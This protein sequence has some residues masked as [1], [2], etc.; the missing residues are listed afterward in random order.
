M[1][2]GFGSLVGCCS[3]PPVVTA[4]VVPV[5]AATASADPDA[6]WIA[7]LHEANA[8]WRAKRYSE[9]LVKVDEA[10]IIRPVDAQ[11]AI[12]GTAAACVLGDQER[13]LFYYRQIPPV[14]RGSVGNYCGKQGVVLPEPPVSFPRLLPGPSVAPPEPPM[15]LPPA[16]FLPPGFLPP[17]EAPPPARPGTFTRLSGGGVHCEANSITSCSVGRRSRGSGRPRPTGSAPPS[18]R[19]RRRRAAPWRAGRDRDRG[20]CRLRSRIAA[21]VSV[22]VSLAEA[23]A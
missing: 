21:G 20:S 19:R 10:L 7:K 18:A 12:L 13:A 15:P 14:H 8:A 23:V 2:V 22:C 11:S 17:P 16:E 9:T 4:P 5:D 1:L 6:R 3:R